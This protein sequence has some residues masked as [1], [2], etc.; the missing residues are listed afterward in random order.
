MTGMFKSIAVTSAKGALGIIAP[1]VATPPKFEDYVHVLQA[2][3]VI[4]VSGGGT[5]G[6]S[7]S[8]GAGTAGGVVI[9]Y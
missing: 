7:H 1:I 3:L 5:N 9:E 6:V 2:L 4:A 8:G